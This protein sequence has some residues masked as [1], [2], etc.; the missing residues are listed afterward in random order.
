MTNTS[1]SQIFVLVRYNYA[2]APP[3]HCMPLGPCTKTVS[4]VTFEEL[5]WIDRMAIGVEN[6]ISN[7][8]YAL[9]KLIC[10]ERRR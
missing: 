1:S 5:P 4:Y 9:I 10:G 3:L 2:G 7:G 6:Q 8:F